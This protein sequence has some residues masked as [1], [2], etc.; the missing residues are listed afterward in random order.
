MGQK[1]DKVIGQSSV[2][3]RLAEKFR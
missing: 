2:A 1:E 3:V